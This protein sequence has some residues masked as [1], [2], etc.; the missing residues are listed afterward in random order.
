MSTRE[1]Y[2][3]LRAEIEAMPDKEFFGRNLYPLIETID[4]LGRVVEAAEELRFV[5]KCHRRMML[6]GITMEEVRE[7]LDTAIANARG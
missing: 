4:A 5:E 6:P 1:E 2:L 7:N 3:E